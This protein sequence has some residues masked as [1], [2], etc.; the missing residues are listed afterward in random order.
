MAA[1][2]IDIMDVRQ[3]IQLKAKGES[4]RSCSSILGVH[5]N[6][7]NYYVR[8]LKATGSPYV[9]LLLL[10]DAELRE[11]FPSRMSS[12]NDRYE[13][14]SQ[15]FSYF[16]QQLLLPGATREVL[17][18][19]YLCKHPEGYGYTQFNEHL[20]TWFGQTKASGKF[21]H[22]AGD[23]LLVDYCG[24]KLHVVDKTTGEVRD[25][26]VFVGILPCSGYTYV[27][28][29]SSQGREDFIASINNCFGFLGGSTKVIVPDNLK[30][31]V[32]KA[33][34]YEPILN[35]TLKDLAFHYGCAINPT[36]TYSPQDKAMVEGAVRLVYQRIYF[37]MRNMTFFSIEELNVQLRAELEKYNAYLMETYQASR[38]K[39]FVDLEQEYL[40]PLPSQ[41][42]QIKHYK[43][44]KVQ[45]MGYIYL[46]DTKNYYS[47]PCRYNRDYTMDQY[48]ALLV[49]LEW[50][51]RYNKRIQNLIKTAGFRYPASVQDVDY[52]ANRSLDKNTFE[53]LAI[54]DFIKRSENVIIT[55]ATGTGKS[56]LAQALG[57]SAC[58]MQYK[59]MYY[60]FARL[61]NQIK[62]SKLEGT[63]MK[64]LNKIEKSDLLILDDFGLTAFDDHARNALMDIV[65]MKYDKS[66]LII[67]AQIPVKNWHEAIGEGTIADAILDRLVYASH[68]IELT[69]ESLRKNKM[70]KSQINE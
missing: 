24:K 6:T 44:A 70:K 33:S 31:A 11:L 15:Y 67:A 62:L 55:G 64:M 27:E 57:Y 21:T 39:L 38:R 2:K 54:L 8:Q 48:L 14:L 42:Y 49:D 20:N 1:K 51:Y 9:S 10:V 13:E 66:S 68:R 37:P 65:E 18:K 59:T 5:R 22:K 53:R 32:T 40:Q 35:K 28:S 45:K 36:R 34:K 3:L 19:E 50:E 47:V 56:Y 4:N 52:S 30:S 61:I 7:I 43:R 69:G 41:P 16:K 58:T 26:E 60:N 12:E 46:S 23:A 29:S 25:V 17:W 63:Y